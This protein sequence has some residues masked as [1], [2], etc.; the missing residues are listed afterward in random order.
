MCLV[1]AA[2]SPSEVMD[3]LRAPPWRQ[4]SPHTLAARV[5]PLSMTSLGHL[6]AGLCQPLPL[7]ARASD[8]ARAGKKV[9]PDPNL[10]TAAAH[11]ATAD[12]ASD[13]AGG[14]SDLGS[15]PSRGGGPTVSR[16]G[17]VIPRA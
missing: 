2:A 8:G 3:R 16:L 1:F 6:R 11:A 12:L 5:P 13:V 4:V 14:S 9:A 7:H 17:G 15:D 10:H